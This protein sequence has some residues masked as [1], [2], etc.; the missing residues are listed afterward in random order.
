MFHMPSLERSYFWENLQKSSRASEV[1]LWV[2]A[3]LEQALVGLA[4]KAVDGLYCP[5][6]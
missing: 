6:H 2:V 5:P 3:S 1:S 4:A